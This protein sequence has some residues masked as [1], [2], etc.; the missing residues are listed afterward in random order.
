[1]DL[2]KGKGVS[3]KTN[4]QRSGILKSFESNDIANSIFQ[5][6]QSL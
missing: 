3:G 1:M 4:E 6:P 5:S 2:K